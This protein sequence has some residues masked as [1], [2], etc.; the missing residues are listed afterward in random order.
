MPHTENPSTWESK[1]E[2]LSSRPAHTTYQDIGSQTRASLFYPTNPGEKY[3]SRGIVC[4]PQRTQWDTCLYRGKGPT[5]APCLGNRSTWNLTMGWFCC[6]SKKAE[7]RTLVLWQCPATPHPPK[8]HWGNRRKEGSG[9]AV[10][11]LSIQFI[12]VTNKKGNKFLTCFSG[13]YWLRCTLISNLIYLV[14]LN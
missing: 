3:F 4:A 10:T 12:T 7:C 6:P 1:A 11:Q 8:Q 5:L 9:E 14:E 2:S 13:K